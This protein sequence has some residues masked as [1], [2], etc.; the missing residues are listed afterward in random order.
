ML[1]TFDDFLVK[2]TSDD[3]FALKGKKSHGHPIKQGF[4]A[5]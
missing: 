4:S 1:F 5:K 3:F 2:V